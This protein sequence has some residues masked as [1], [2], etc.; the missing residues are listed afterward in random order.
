M[1]VSLMAPSSILVAFFT[2]LETK[3]R[4]QSGVMKASI[5]KLLS[6]KNGK[7]CMVAVAGFLIGVPLYALPATITLPRGPRPGLEPLTILLAAERLQLTGKTGWDLVNS[8]RK[9]VGDRMIYCRRNSFDT[10]ARAFER[11]YGYCTQQ[12]YAFVSLLRQ[13]GFEQAEVVH[14]FRNHFF[15]MGSEGS[16]AWVC[17]TIDNETRHLDTLFYDE[18]AGKNTFVPLSEVRT[19]SPLFKIVAWWGGTAVNAHRFYLSG[20]DWS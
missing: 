14:A 7:I 11:G 9:L 18:E 6:R 1:T 16:H 4:K 17:V 20:K 3:G 2:R 8:A 19:M 10:A 12:A 13:L 15:E 5:S